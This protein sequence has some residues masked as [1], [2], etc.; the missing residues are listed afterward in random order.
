VLKVRLATIPAQAAYLGAE[1]DLAQ[2]WAGRIGSKGFKVGICWRGNSNIKADPNRSIP[3]SAFIALGHVGGVRLI[4]IQKTGENFPRGD[5]DL[6]PGIETLGGDF[7]SGA[8]A[9]IDAA[10][11][12]QSLDLIITCDTSIAHLAGAL[13]RPVWVVLKQTAD[14]RWLLERDDCPWYPT[15][16]LFRQ[17]RLGDWAE[18]FHRVKQALLTA[19]TIG[20][21]RS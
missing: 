20:D 6:F 17:T 5:L 16:R 1:A 10:A 2:M 12:M 19:V 13:S 15:M 7:D 18:V 9:F 4:S 3:L 14:L 11:A 8:E 21:E